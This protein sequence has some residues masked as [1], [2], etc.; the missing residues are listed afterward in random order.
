MSS[1]VSGWELAYFWEFWPNFLCIESVEW[2]CHDHPQQFCWGIKRRYFGKGISFVGQKILKEI[3]RWVLG[4]TYLWY[5][6]RSVAQ[7][8]YVYW[9]KIVLLI[10]SNIYH[11]WH[12]L[13]LYVIVIYESQIIAQIIPQQN[14]FPWHKIYNNF[15]LVYSVVYFY[16][17][18]L[19]KIVP[20]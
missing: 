2:M 5:G 18:S 14:I 1:K 13:A 8:L 9:Y 16:I 17:T 11:E 19:C 20:A 12:S 15:N 7:N 6:Q 10:E 4:K 3:F